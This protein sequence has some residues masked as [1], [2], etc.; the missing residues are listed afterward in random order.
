MDCDI[1]LE[2]IIGTALSLEDDYPESYLPIRDKL[3]STP[4]SICGTISDLLPGAQVQV[5]LQ[6][7]WQQTLLDLY[8]LLG[9][10]QEP[11]ASRAMHMIENEDHQSTAALSPG[12]KD[13]PCY[14]SESSSCLKRPLCEEEQSLSKK[15]KSEPDD[16]LPTLGARSRKRTIYSK[17]QTNFLQNQFD[18]NP[19]PDFVSRCHLAQL[20][21]IPEP[22]IQVWFKNRRAR[23]L[24]KI[25]RSHK[26]T[27]HEASILTGTQKLASHVQ[28]STIP[29]G[30]DQNLPGR[31]LHIN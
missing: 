30:Q 19:Y 9:F 10:P 4:N 11:K 16:L 17:E 29:W 31:F 26:N 22:R 28:Q 8:S 6:N 21:G 14:I 20:T 2:Q 3:K 25:H 7:T 27:V 15:T 13:K 5:P 12:I 24:S 1:E 23:H 18:V